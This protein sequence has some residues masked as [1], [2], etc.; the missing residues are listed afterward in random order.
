MNIWHMIFICHMIWTSS[1]PF[2]SH[3][4]SS[5]CCSNNVTHSPFQNRCSYLHDPATMSMERNVVILPVKAKKHNGDAVVDPLFHEYRTVIHQK[6]PI[7]PPHIWEKCRPSRDST[8]E[9]M[10]FEDTYALA[11]NNTS[12]VSNVLPTAS[13]E[14]DLKEELTKLCIVNKMVGT[15]HK[16]T[17]DP[18][19]SKC[20][21]C[22]SILYF[23]FISRHISNADQ[24][25]VLLFHV[26]VALNG[27]P[28][29]VLRT[30]YFRLLDIVNTERDIVV[31]VTALVYQK[32][33]L[34]SNQDSFVCAHEV[35]FGPKGMSTC[36]HSM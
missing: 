14:H 1:P 34:S 6:N 9:S 3:I 22:C 2:R 27:Q 32:G 36:N 35:V 24:S 20:L 7:V 29:M 21:P 28:C 15:R 33:R 31:E 19:H 30:E 23:R 13:V 25:S 8:H 18:Q 10:A 4:F 11:C 16:F 17:Y 12:A 5:C 26:Y